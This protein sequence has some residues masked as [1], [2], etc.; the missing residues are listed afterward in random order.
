MTKIAPWMI[1]I[2]MLLVSVSYSQTYVSGKVEGIW[3][4]SNSPY[5]VTDDIYVSNGSWE[6]LEIEPGVEVRFSSNTRFTI[7]GKLFA[8]GTA[9]DSIKFISNHPDSTWK[10]LRFEF[11]W[12]SNK[13]EL[14]YIV[15][16][17]ATDNGIYVANADYG[18][19][20]IKNSTLRNNNHWNTGGLFAWK[21]YFIVK[22]C[23]FDGNSS[24]NINALLVRDSKVKLINCMFKNNYNGNGLLGCSGED[25]E[26]YVYNSIFYNNS[27][28]INISTT[29]KLRLINCTIYDNVN[30]SFEG[31]TFIENTIIRNHTGLEYDSTKCSIRYSNIE[32]GTAGIGNID[33]KPLFADA[34]NGDF[35]LQTNSPCINAGNSASIYNDEDGS[36]NDMGAFGG[37][38]IY[39]YPD[40]LNYGLA[41]KGQAKVDSV[42]ILNAR[43]TPFTITSYTFSDPTNF[44]AALALPDTVY[45]LS[46]KNIKLTF[47]PNTTGQI[48]EKIILTSP[49]IP[50]A[51]SLTIHLKGRAGYWSGEV[52]GTWSRSN[53]PIILGGDILIPSGSL[54]K[55]EPGVIV[56]V[57]TNL[58]GPSAEIV[59]EGTFVAVGTE[60]DSILFTVTGEKSPGMWD[61]IDL[62]LVS[63]TNSSMN[64]KS[65]SP[66]LDNDEMT[67]ILNTE[68][69]NTSPTEFPRKN[70]SGENTNN[71]Q[72][73]NSNADG[74]AILRY[75]IIEYAKT[76]ITV[77]HS[78]VS[79]ENSTIRHNSD[80]GIHWDGNE[81]Y[82][83]GELKNSTVSNNG[84]WGIY[85]AAFCFDTGG[86]ASP[87]IT[88]NTITDNTEGGIY[89]LADGWVPS[90]YVSRLKSATAS[91]DIESN[92]I[93]NNTGFGIKCY[94]GGDWEQG[95]PFNAYRK[96]F[97]NPTIKNNIIADN[98]RGLSATEAWGENPSYADNIRFDQNTFWENSEYDILASDSAKLL[99]SNSI[100]WNSNANHIQQTDGGQAMICYSD[101]PFE[102][103]GEGN[104]SEAPQFSNAQT[105]DFSLT[106]LSPCIDTGHPDS[107]ADTDGTRADM[108]ALYYHQSISDFALSS[109][110]NDTTIS[111]LWTEFKWQLPA[112]AGNEPLKFVLLYSPASTFADSNTVLIEDIETNSYMVRD[113]LQDLSTYYWKVLTQN[114]WG[115]Q[116]WCLQ[117]WQFTINTDTIA[118]SIST[119][120]E[121]T[122][123]EDDS[124]KMP[125]DFWFGYIEDNRWPDST[126][127]VNLNSG[128]FVTV[129][130][131]K[132]SCHFK[133]KISN[134]F[135]R[136]TLNLTVADSSGLTNRANFVVHVK[137][138]NDAPAINELPDSLNIK[139]DSTVVLELW[140]FTSDI[141]TPDSLLQFDFDAIYDQP[142]TDDSLFWNFDEGTGILSLKSMNYKGQVHFSISAMD[143]SFATATDTIIINITYPTHVEGTD[144]TLPTVFR[145]HQ[146]YPNPFNPTTSISY[147]LPKSCDVI[148]EVYNANGQKVKTLVNGRKMAGS[149]RVKFDAIDE[150][151]TPISSGIYF[152]ILKAGDFR[153]IKKLTLIK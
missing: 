114:P 30:H 100:I 9:E 45:P 79:I 108:G 17:N 11:K 6:K 61:G 146:N 26:L 148:I 31:E 112:T 113:S 124:L 86:E 68:N 32:G 97:T 57:D 91:P 69:D 143:D 151:G 83:G 50:G 18:E 126:L 21:S 103:A 93:V 24:D 39:I 12:L 140:N 81:R 88:G 105:H 117:T 84:Q 73:T 87:L 137:S 121:I 96:A 47:K 3:T 153:A 71:S 7:N 74:T 107:T 115:M 125:I 58:A 22:D 66:D 94:A 90:G 49:D 53:S 72:S 52:W 13:A 29:T 128:E 111:T 119:L 120:P 76:G 27:N 130:T 60:N 62:R 59:A 48:T 122:F 132:D 16:S 134:W 1:I 142:V 54:L 20:I 127:S 98:T 19:F 42:H 104:I 36:R 43:T 75:C 138:V 10:G 129:A 80:H 41:G 38:G 133:T 141:E 145:L 95:I 70:L 118:P 85:C 33:E 123:N 14:E 77:K 25:S 55:I 136:D 101:L 135:G 144:K 89:V 8:K 147:D 64:T 152:Y 106:Y 35:Q 5:I 150:N 116:K 37:S 92:F 67:Q 4:K 102:I 149:H 139:S 78:N 131:T 110:E 40:T 34:Q 82:I 2:F 99:I 15:V 65:L 56:K 109:P 63:S 28:D 51:D 44:I 23:V 46:E